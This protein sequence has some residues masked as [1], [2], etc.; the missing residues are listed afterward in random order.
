MIDS[1]D[2]MNL[3]SVVSLKLWLV[4]KMQESRGEFRKFD[5]TLSKMPK[6]GRTVPIYL[7][8]RLV[9]PFDFVVLLACIR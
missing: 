2:Q 7:R 5:L 6:A 4:D 9:I 3:G 8:Y 1:S